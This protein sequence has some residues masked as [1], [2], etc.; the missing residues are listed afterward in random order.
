M[1]PGFEELC[2]SENGP[3]YDALST[4]GFL[5]RLLKPDNQW[6]PQAYGVNDVR[7]SARA[8]VLAIESPPTS[9][10]G[11]KRFIIV[12][13]EDGSYR[14]AVNFIAEER[15]HLK[16]RLVDVERVPTW[17]SHT[18]AVDRKRIEEVIGFKQDEYTTW[19]KTVIDSV[20]SLMKLE[21]F[22]RERGFEVVVPGTHPLS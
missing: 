18:K 14:N 2:I 16:D 21:E 9:I 1:A 6:F 4:S 12:T 17:P 13:P 11:R 15:P 5:Y 10:V 19:K 3:N 20:D 8:H 7:D 22:W